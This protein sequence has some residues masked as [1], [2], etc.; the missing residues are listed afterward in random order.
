MFPVTC[1][2]INHG[3]SL[4][5]FIIWRGGVGIEPTTDHKDAVTLVLQTRKGASPLTP[6]QLTAG[7]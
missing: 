3:F 4:H 2:K 7:R 5:L 6:R 1:T